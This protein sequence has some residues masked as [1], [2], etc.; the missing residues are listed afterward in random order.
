MLLIASLTGG[1]EILSIDIDEDIDLAS[2]LLPSQRYLV[3]NGDEILSPRLVCIGPSLNCEVLCLSVIRRPFCFEKYRV[4]PRFFFKN[5]YRNGI[6][7]ASRQFKESALDCA[8]FIGMGSPYVYPYVVLD[9]GYDPSVFVAEYLRTITLWFQCR[10]YFVGISLADFS[11]EDHRWTNLMKKR[12]WLN[13]WKLEDLARIEAADWKLFAE[14]S[15]PN[16][17]AKYRRSV[18]TTCKYRHYWFRKGLSTALTGL[19]PMI[20]SSDI[21][22]DLVEELSVDWAIAVFT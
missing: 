3:I 22:V 15:I 11:F 12:Q 7:R 18:V 5:A 6:R 9:V 10:R 21:G 2:V 4:V 13:L 1:E 8:A 16:A 14:M 20:V 17:M 19:I